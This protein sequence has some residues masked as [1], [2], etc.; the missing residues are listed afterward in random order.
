MTG[1]AVW[2]DV[3]PD[4]S[5]FGPQVARESSKAAGKAGKDSGKAWATGF[6]S[7]ADDGG[8]QAAVAQLE[9]AARRSKKAVEDQT[10]AIRRA[11]AA[12]RDATAK[13][14]LAEEKLR[15]AREKYGA[16]S[17]QATAASQRLEAARSRQ[18]ATASKLASTE[19][20]L[21]AASRE[22]AE[23][24]SQLADE[25][26]KAATKT[27]R[28]ASSWDG[29]KASLGTANGRIS[30]ATSSTEGLAT[31]LV[32]TAGAALTFAEAWS[33][34]LDLEKGTDKIAASLDL[35]EQQ[36]AT[37][38]QVAGEL[39][40]DAY[41]ESM[42][43]VT[44]AVES[45]ISSIDGMGTAS[46]DELQTVTE[47]ALNTAS[48]F[49]V[50]LN[51]ATRDAGILMKTGLAGDAT[52]AFD[53]ITAA[54][55]QVPSAMRGEVLAAT[56][57][58]SGFLAQL[59]YDGT[60]AMSLITSATENGAYGIDKVG[61]SLKELT[62]SAADAAKSEAFTDLGLNQQQINE[63]FVEGGDSAR[64]A[65]GKIVTALQSVEDPGARA[66]AAI[67]LFGTP[68]EDLGTNDIPAFLESLVGVE[69]GL[70]NVEGRAATMGETLNDNA[71]TGLVGLKR[72]FIDLVSDGVSPF[73]GPATTVLDWVRET[74]GALP[75]ISAA[76]GVV[77]GAW[78]I[79]TVAQW[80]ANSALLAFPGTWIVLAIAAVIASIVL[81][82]ANWDT[83]SAAL[84]DG[85][86]WM[87]EHVFKPAGDWFADVGGWFADMGR[88]IAATWSDTGDALGAG[89]DW[90]VANVLQPF[91]D[92]W[93]AAGDWFADVGS[94][95]GQSWD[96]TIGWLADGWFW[97]DR[98]VLQP[99]DDG[100]DALGVVFD[101]LPAIVR[102]AMDKVRENAARPVNFV[103]QTV[104]MDGIRKTWNRIADAVGVD[105]QLPS[106]APIQFAAGGVLPGYSPGVD[107]HRFFSPTAGWLELSGGEA[108]M[109]PE[110]TRA[111]GGPAAV[112]GMNAD[113]KAGRFADG[114]IWSWAGD[115]VDWLK[116]AGSTVVEVLT[117]PV[118]A[119]NDAILGPVRSLLGR[120]G[121]GAIGDV[122]TAL[123]ERVIDALGSTVQGL[124][125]TGGAGAPAGALGW[126]NMWQIV[127]AAFPSAVLTSAYRPGAIT[128]TGF[129]SYHGLGRAIDVSPSMAIFNWL[130]STFPRST[131]LIYSPAG[132]R[133]LRG[134]VPTLFGE[135][136]RGDHWDHIHWAMAGG[137]VLPD[138][139]VFDDGGW[140]PP[141]RSLVENRTG[142]PEPLARLDVERARAGTGM[143]AMPRVLEVRDVD[144]ELVG[145]MRVE[146]GAVMTGRVTP[147]DEERSTW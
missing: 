137:G 80:A 47:A 101:N 18:Q 126:Q 84:A 36:S 123:P 23:I 132:A 53:L 10:Y 54:L 20:A 140:L 29:L 89:Y 108:I 117:D 22:H 35:T 145:R 106:V 75:A 96:D 90:V 70:G 41:G 112:A 87:V 109:R 83:V 103:I 61:D 107:V 78:G 72:S 44:G 45:V 1:D 69:D 128:A 48:A 26:S 99:F 68:L 76:L 52:E 144:G 15:E 59:G 66:S 92:G 139:L 21:R 73:L 133:Q 19:D 14:T 2:L 16:S 37:A 147:M 142:Q 8:T 94:D 58:Y 30:D 65:M 39:Y 7:T 33:E 34:G 27:D 46:A 5:N 42:G 77:A 43:E 125:S 113:A 95:I 121:G 88:G 110:W 56:E 63:A 3:L 9:D 85:W 102:V 111:V 146:A 100:I 104:Y 67:E 60:E 13:V 122:V 119:I 51:E 38:G 105:L 98:H 17:A 131:E 143:A 49:D 4:M 138:P 141:G 71:A 12:E 118:G 97:I 114:G 134:G 6:A 40:S 24:T 93:R 64:D 79:Y 129:P 62:L 50:D 135:P 86:D 81:I 124:V 57:E 120:V 130:A 31:Q 55:Q 115:A 28:A 116:D 11:R 25:T 32:L 91:G 127:Q 136:T 74:N 82:A